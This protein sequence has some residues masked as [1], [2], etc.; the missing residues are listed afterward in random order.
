MKTML[1]IL[2]AIAMNLS[3][4]AQAEDIQVGNFFTGIEAAITKERALEIIRA[5]TRLNGYADLRRAKVVDVLDTGRRYRCDCFDVLVK[6]E[7]LP[8]QYDSGGR[9]WINQV[10]IKQ[11]QIDH[12]N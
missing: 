7:K 10:R 9:F 4:I 6:Y 8:S 11:G 3:S 12:P 1:V 2:T 5:D